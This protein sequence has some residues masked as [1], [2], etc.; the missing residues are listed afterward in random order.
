M[1]LYYYLPDHHLKY[2]FLGEKSTLPVII[3]KNLENSQ[4][5]RL[6]EILKKNKKAIR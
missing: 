3:S 5:E 2:A 1:Y 4:E 6:M